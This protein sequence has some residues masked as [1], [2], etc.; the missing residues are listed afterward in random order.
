MH[1]LI[2][3]SLNT[4]LTS[5]HALSKSLRVVSATPSLGAGVA[6]TFGGAAAATV[7]E[8]VAASGGGAAMCEPP[9]PVAGTAD[10]VAGT[11]ASVQ[12]LTRS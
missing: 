2:N 9:P 5:V 1:Q 8:A 12:S 10:S 6:E 11:A 7:G 4:A 3:I